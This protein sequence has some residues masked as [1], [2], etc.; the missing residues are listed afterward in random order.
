[1]HGSSPGLD[2]VEWAKLVARHNGRCAY[3]GEP[4]PAGEELARD[5][6]IPLTRYSGADFGPDRIGN[7][8]PACGQCNSRKYN[9]LLAEWRYRDG[10]RI[11][12][13]G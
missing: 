8:L 12:C 6:V 1:M 7:V 10:V 13:M 9:K 3:C 2:A 11:A 5:H 4:P